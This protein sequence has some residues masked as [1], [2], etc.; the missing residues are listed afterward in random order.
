MRFVSTSVGGTLYLV[1]TPIGNREDITLRALAVL[2]AVDFIL[3]EDTRHSAPLLAFFGINQP[4]FSFHAHNE[5]VQTKP[6][7]EK[8]I[9]G[10]S[11]ALIS[12]AGSPLICDPGY[13]LV[14]YARD[15]GVKVVPIPGACAL[16]TALSASGVP[17]DRFTFIGFLPAKSTAR[18]EQLRQFLHLEQTLVC[19]ESTHRIVACVD[20]LIS[21]YGEACQVVLAKEL[22]KTFESFVSDSL[23]KV[24]DWLHADK[25]HQK[26]EFV[27][28]IPPRAP[29][30][31]AYAADDCLK[32]LS[33][34][35]PL[36]QAVKLTA[37]LTGLS[38]N[39]LYARALAN[40][41]G[42]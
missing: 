8:I 2:R 10:E 13:P 20:D 30:A 21:I 23:A 36:K 15:M 14:R 24:R 33:Q 37:Q 16:I 22:T 4:L 27:V 35:L 32:V 5:L 38:K 31:T 18:K 29:A 11:A 41:A 12:D 40:Q 17:C 19:Y 28:I 42:E 9:Q 34:E 1:A 6:F 3:A 26:G 39:V 7:L 25:A